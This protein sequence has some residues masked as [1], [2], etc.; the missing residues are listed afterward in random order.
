MT[1]LPLRRLGTAV[2]LLGSVVA[3]ACAHTPFEKKATEKTDMMST[4]TKRTSQ[5]SEYPDLTAEEAGRRILNLVDGLESMDELP[6][7]RVI[8]RTGFP[9]EYSPGGQLYSFSMELPGNSGFYSVIYREKSGRRFAEIR[10]DG[11][12]GGEHS[13]VFPCAL[14]ATAVSERL[15]ALGYS[16]NTDID[17]IG[18]TNEYMF[19]KNR[20]HV[21]VVPS[22]HSMPSPLG[23]DTCVAIL[24][25]QSKD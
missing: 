20:L 10:Y 12:E 3:S 2:L 14:G 18:R 25:I 23:T 22:G 19:T 13:D 7:D 8:E 17:E 9:L 6:L 5:A 1:P 24:T 21:R 15:K 4:D 16:M 11:P